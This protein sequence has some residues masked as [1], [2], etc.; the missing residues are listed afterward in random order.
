MARQQVLFESESVAVGV[1]HCW[2]DD[3]RWREVNV[4][5][6]YPLVVFPGT[7]VEIQHVGRRPVL[8]NANHV[9]FYGRGDEYLRRVHDER[10]DHCV[11]FALKPPLAE[12]LLGGDT[13]GFTQGPGDPRVYLR[14]LALV[15]ELKNAE[16]DPLD[17][18]ERALEIADDALGVAAAYHCRPPRFRRGR[19]ERDHHEL[20]EAAKRLLTERFEERLT[21]EEIA[22]ALH[23][24]AFHLARVFRARTGFSLHGYRNQLRLRSALA[25]ITSP[26]CDLAALAYELGFSNH[27]HFTGAFRAAFGVPPSALRDA[28]P[29]ARRELRTNVEARLATRS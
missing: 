6:F 22:R 8:S 4:V 25:R 21:L 28:S 19:T 11:Y 15:R 18:E 20:A 13:V 27:S 3:D 2:P 1:F 14:H 24:S 9:M 17:A 29:R 5:P 16:A 7:S 10:G 12:R 23:T 26:H